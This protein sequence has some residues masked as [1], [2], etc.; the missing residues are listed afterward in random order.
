[1]RA[2]PLSIIKKFFLL[3]LNDDILNSYEYAHAFV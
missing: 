3:F 2:N 1:M